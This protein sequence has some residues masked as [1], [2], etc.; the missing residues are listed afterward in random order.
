MS[1]PITVYF[2]ASA[3]GSVKIDPSEVEGMTD[4]EIRA[5]AHES[6][7]MMVQEQLSLSY[8]LRGVRGAIRLIREAH[9]ELPAKLDS[10]DGVG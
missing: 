5:Y 8:T 7:E 1:K 9:R 10:G 3:S 6:A 2:E 4:A